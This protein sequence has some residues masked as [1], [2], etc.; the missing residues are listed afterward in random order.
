ML[1][2]GLTLEDTDKGLHEGLEAWHNLLE[3]FRGHLAFV[4][5]LAFAN[6]VSSFHSMLLL[7]RV[8]C[9]LTEVTH[10]S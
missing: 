8:S 4:Q 1:V 2:G 7:C 9:Q 5:Q 6:G 10:I 3:N